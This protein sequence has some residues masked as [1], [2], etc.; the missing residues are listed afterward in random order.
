VQLVSGRPLRAFP[1]GADLG[2][3]RLVDLVVGQAGTVLVLDSAAPQ[4]L[5]LRAGG[6]ALERLA[7]LEVPEAASV[8]VGGDEGTAFVAHRDGVSRV[9]LRS[10]TASPVAVPKGSPPGRLMRIRWHGAGLIAVQRD[11]DGSSRLLRL[12]MNAR[13]TEITRVTRLET[14]PPADGQAFV[15]ISG[16]QLVYVGPS[17]AQD[18][19]RPG[20]ASSSQGEFVAYRVPLR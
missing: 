9:D 18:G 14:S 5:V 8:A 19:S 1:V 10:R 7:R 6:T 2:P 16:D 4:L 17:S 20:D 15:T 13:G 3:A 12:E 11:V